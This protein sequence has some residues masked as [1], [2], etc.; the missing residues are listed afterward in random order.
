MI[1][2]DVSMNEKTY[3]G[4]FLVSDS[5][6]DNLLLGWDWM[7]PWNLGAIVG[8]IANCIYVGLKEGHRVFAL[9]EAWR[10]THS[11]P[12]TLKEQVNH[13]F[14]L[15]FATGFW[16][17]LNRHQHIFNQGSRLQWALTIQHEIHLTNKQAFRIPVRG[18]SETHKKVIDTDVPE[19]LA[20]GIVEPT[21]SPYNS[22]PVIQKRRIVR[23]D[24]A[25]TSVN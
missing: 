19:M 3:A 8:N 14:P 6:R 20:N 10:I 5:L 16:K 12:E 21:F 17:I 22:P 2:L 23:N 4:T 25:L 24:S 11:T 18:Y 7:G 15:P 1:N 9:P 13:Y